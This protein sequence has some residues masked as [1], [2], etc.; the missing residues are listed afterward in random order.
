MPTVALAEGVPEIWEVVVK[1]AGSTLLRRE[2]AGFRVQA[3]LTQS[4]KAVA[5]LSD[6]DMDATVNV[7]MDVV[8]DASTSENVK[9]VAITMLRNLALVSES[10]LRRVRRPQPRISRHW[11]RRRQDRAPGVSLQR[12]RP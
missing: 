3:H 4:G 11:R 9:V 6:D 8:H 1:A 7:A 12:A 10:R 2:G 5:Q